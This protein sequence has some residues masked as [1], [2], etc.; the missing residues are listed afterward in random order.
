MP[1]HPSMK[2][3]SIISRGTAGGD[4]VRR[5]DDDRQ[6]EGDKREKGR[7]LDSKRAVS[8]AVF[9]CDA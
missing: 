9:L 8:S 5:Y 7:A 6:N 2:P 4:V 3:L 1:I